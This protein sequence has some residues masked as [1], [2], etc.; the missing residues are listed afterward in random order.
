MRESRKEF[1]GL[2]R[3]RRRKRAGL[4]RPGTDFPPSSDQRLNDLPMGVR[5]C[6]KPGSAWRNDVISG[7]K[8]RPCTM[9]KLRFEKGPSPHY[10]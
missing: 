4:M 1:W 10:F 6:L 8:L 3:Q 5:Q 9:C 7:T 2:G